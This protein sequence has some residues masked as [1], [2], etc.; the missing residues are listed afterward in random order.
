M[1]VEKWR[2]GARI[3]KDGR[4]IILENESL[5]KEL[6]KELNKYLKKDKKDDK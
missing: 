6:V 1:Q 4:I 3:E 5:V 2:Y